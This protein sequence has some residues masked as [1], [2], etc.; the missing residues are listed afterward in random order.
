MKQQY[1]IAK[2]H[3]YNNTLLHVKKHVGTFWEFCPQVP[4]LWATCI[5][6][7]AACRGVS[8]PQVAISQSV[9]KHALHAINM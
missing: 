6:A 4:T 7:V 9:V 2:M 3:Y 1:I 8:P 5:W